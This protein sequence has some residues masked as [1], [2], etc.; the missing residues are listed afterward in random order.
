MLDLESRGMVDLKTH[1]LAA[2]I[3]GLTALTLVTWQDVDLATGIAGPVEAWRPM[4]EQTPETLKDLNGLFVAY[5]MRYDRLAWN[6]CRGLYGLP[7]LPV[8]KVLDLMVQCTASGLPEGLA[9]AAESVGL[10]AKL[11]KK[12]ML[13]LADAHNALPSDDAWAQFVEYGRR[14]T[15]LLWP[16]W[17]RTHPVSASSWAQWHCS[18]R[19]NDRGL[20]MDLELAQAIAAAAKVE[21]AAN[22]AQMVELCG[23]R[24]QQSVALSR[25]VW[26]RLDDVARG[27]MSPDGKSRSL[28]TKEILPALLAETHTPEVQAVLEALEGSK[29]PASGKAAAILKTTVRGRATGCYV[30]NGASTGRFSSRGVQVHNLARRISGV[31]LV[32]ALLAGEPLDPGPVRLPK[33]LSAALRGCI[34]AG[35]GQTLV[36]CDWSA[37]E[38]RVLPWL[39][40]DPQGVRTAGRKADRVLDLFRAGEDIY[41]DAARGIYRLRAGVE[42]TKEQRQVGK[43]SCLAC[44]YGGSVGAFERMAALFGVRVE[45]PKAI[46]TAWREAN[47]WA[48]WLWSALEQAMA[49]AYAAPGAAYTVGR[50]VYSMDG[51]DLLCR[52]PS[53]RRLVYRKIRRYTE[54]DVYGHRRVVWEYRRGGGRVRLWGGSLSENLAQATAADLLRDAL[55][56]AEALG[57]VGHTHDEIILEVPEGVATERYEALHQI[58]VTGPVWADGLPLAAEGD[59]GSRYGK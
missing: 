34:K 41:L 51:R 12:G 39:A 45:D 21:D 50:V 1:G 23:L 25:W 22:E 13:F 55:C 48:V 33:A 3:E 9:R 14:D 57:V 16:L 53:G 28:S 11:D 30:F 31:D 24:P 42:V 20:P 49:S 32:P 58:M 54:D 19:I 8:E 38:A 37:I 2:H 15:E 43:T 4:T 56:R 6:Q 26:D 5:N 36:W 29:S 7:L 52:L 47:P 59:I 46:V 40:F 44:G 35:E 18:E 17:Q 27:I 10:P